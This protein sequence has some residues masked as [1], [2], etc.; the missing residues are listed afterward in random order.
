VEGYA[1]KFFVGYIIN[2]NVVIKYTP[3]FASSACVIL[4]MRRSHF[5]HIYNVKLQPCACKLRRVCLHVTSWEPLNAFSQNVIL[6]NFTKIC[7]NIAT[8]V[9]VGQE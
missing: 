5:G 6:G 9:T 7:R 4:Y 3:I 2:F 8:L 1:G